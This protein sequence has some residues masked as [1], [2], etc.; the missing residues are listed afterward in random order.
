MEGEIECGQMCVCG[1]GVCGCVCVCLCVR[2]CMCVGV[3]VCACV[4]VG[5]CGCVSCYSTVLLTAGHTHSFSTWLTLP[6]VE[7]NTYKV[8]PTRICVC[9]CVCVL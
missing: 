9:V 6:F 2:G 1:G 7:R 4:W 8:H 5:G 3:C